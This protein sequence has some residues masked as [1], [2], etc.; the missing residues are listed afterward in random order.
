M[1]LNPEESHCHFDAIDASRRDELHRHHVQFWERVA[2]VREERQERLYEMNKTP[3]SHPESWHL[4]Q[5]LDICRFKPWDYTR[6]RLH[7]S[8]PRNLEL[9]DLKWRAREYLR[10][11][12]ELLVY[13][14]TN[15]FDL[16]K[17]KR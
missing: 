17:S 1:K 6:I 16:M 14:Y 7:P 10:A 9:E 12:E 2:Q 15:P 8:S 13:E 11:C 3:D 5:M 4:N